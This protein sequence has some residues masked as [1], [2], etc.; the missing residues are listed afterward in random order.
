MT[1]RDRT[2]RAFAA[3][4]AL[5][6]A[7]TWFRSEMRRQ[8]AAFGLTFRGFR[9]LDML[10]RDGP[11]HMGE[12]ARV[13]EMKP[14][15]ILDIVRELEDLGWVEGEQ[16]AL[17]PV[18]NRWNR[19]LKSQGAPRKIGARVR[20]LRLTPLGEK[21]I[22]HV[23]PKHAKVVKAWMKALDGREQQSLTRICR[24]L[25]GGDIIKFFKEM[26]FIDPDEATNT[27]PIETKD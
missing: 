9:I 17:E 27:W 23:F 26:R 12:L 7:A 3:F 20:R 1:H 18:D 24:K 14:Q 11:S 16:T 6:D 4:Q 15:H 13:C 2:R 10:Y 22:G 8:L 25:K 5:M 19:R 21:F